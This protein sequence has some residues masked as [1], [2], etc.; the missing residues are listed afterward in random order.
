MFYNRSVV[1]RRSE[2][3]RVWRIFCDGTAVPNNAQ[4][5]GAIGLGVVVVD[6]TGAR[7]DLSERSDHRGDNND[8]EGLALVRALEFARSVGAKDEDAV[9]VVCDSSIVV[10]NTVGPKRT[11][12]VGLRE[13]FARARD[14]LSAF[15]SASV[16]NVP[17]RRNADA[18]VLARAAVGLL[19]KPPPKKKRRR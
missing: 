4:K 8:A 16:E 18:D 19:P 11:M 9:V 1:E 13:I 7:H 14:A 5:N 17:R 3:R 2:P 10:E 6:D 12:V 15:H